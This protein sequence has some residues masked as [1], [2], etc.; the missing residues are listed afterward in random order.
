MHLTQ[1]DATPR[2]ARLTSDVCYADRQTA[3]RPNGEALESTSHANLA[4]FLRQPS[5]HRQLALRR[6]RQRGRVLSLL[7]GD[8]RL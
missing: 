1:A 2:F 3:I 4:L 8:S 5:V 7:P 6:L